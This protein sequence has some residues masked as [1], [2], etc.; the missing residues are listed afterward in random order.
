MAA[1]VHYLNNNLKIPALGA[2]TGKLKGETGVQAI[3][4]AIDAGYRLFDTAFLYGNEDI[5]GQAIS[6]KITEGVV[7]RDEIFIIGKLWGIHHD[8]VERA[9]RETCQRLKVDNVDLYLLH[10]PVSFTF[11]NDSEK[12]P[13]DD[14]V[15]DKDYMDVWVE[16]EKL[17]HLGLTKNIGVSNF[18]EKQLER[19]YRLSNLKPKCHEIEFHPG[20]TRYSLLKL[21]RELNISVI[22]YCPLGRHKLEKQE[23]KFLYDSKVQEIAE[24][25]NK[26]TAQVALRFSVQSN[27]I[28]IPKSATKSRLKENIDVFNFQLTEDEVSYLKNFHDEANQICLFH[29][30]TRS[31]HY[32]F[33]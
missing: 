21:C 13:K 20:F 9:C 7:K 12:W 26:T 10:F 27:V 30:A 32:P 16:M 24:K 4:D 18:N 1:P 17:V 25:Y 22:A 5:V 28:P 8:Q 3:K 31:E 29:F 11:H 6:E 2:G 33:K 23:P 19:V 15:L 14:D